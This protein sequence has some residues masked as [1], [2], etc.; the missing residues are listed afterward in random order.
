VV[1]RIATR[2]GIVIAALLMSLPASR[3]VGTPPQDRNPL[4]TLVE[5]TLQR[6]ST[7]DAVAA[8]KWGT[9]S[10]IDDPAR[11]AQ[12]YDSMAKLGATKGLPVAWI[13][14]VFFGQI[15][16]NKVVQRG[17]HTRWQFDPAA[18]PTTRPDLSTV[19]PE[20]DHVNVALIDEIAAHR[21]SLIGP[22]CAVNLSR[23]VFGVVTS[24]RADVLHNAALVRATAALCAP[25]ST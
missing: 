9:A 15:E 21:D 19:R 20:I 12:V 5:L 2:L 3:A 17:L 7:G 8:A 16:A 6:L 13:R 1:S 22:A 18:A 24:G 14:S 23:S 4:D 10:P 11:E 25:M